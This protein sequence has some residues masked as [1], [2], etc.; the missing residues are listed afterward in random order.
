MGKLMAILVNIPADTTSCS[1]TG[2][3]FARSFNMSLET[4]MGIPLDMSVTT[5]PTTDNAI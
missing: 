4:V 3:L 2:F 5:T 1:P